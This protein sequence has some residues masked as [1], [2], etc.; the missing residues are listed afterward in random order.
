MRVA[1]LTAPGANNPCNHLHRA[2]ATL[3]GEGVISHTL[4]LKDWGQVLDVAAESRPDVIALAGAAEPACLRALIGAGTHLMLEP[5]ALAPEEAEDLARTARQSGSIIALAW[6]DTAYPMSRA[7][8]WMLRERRLG[9]VHAVFV[10]HTRARPAPGG[11]AASG[12]VITSLAPAAE[13]FLSTVTGLKVRAVCA[14]AVLNP[15]TRGHDDAQILLRLEGHS[16]GVM[17]LSRTG[18]RAR[19]AVR[20]QGEQGTLEWSTSAPGLVR[21]TPVGRPTEVIT[22]AHAE[23]GPLAAEA[24]RSAG[25]NEGG[26]EALANLY[27]GMFEAVRAKREGRARKGLGREFP[28]TVDL[29]RACRFTAAALDSARA[30]G[31]WAEL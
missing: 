1:L 31:V 9:Q 10:E 4:A 23:A 2:A 5:P 27:R 19:L 11:A 16:R 14:E 3:D 28:T 21:V 6:A 29:T 12:H 26:V 13:C 8:L 18:A 7:A 15:V 25:G 30:G 22:A 20:V 24:V 17:T